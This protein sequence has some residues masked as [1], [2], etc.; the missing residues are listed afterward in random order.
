VSR[1]S[2]ERVDFL[3]VP[4]CRLS[5]EGVQLR[6]P[7]DHDLATLVELAATPEGVLSDAERHY[8]TWLDKPADSIAVDLAMEIRNARHL[9]QAGHWTLN[10]AVVVDE[11][12]I[13]LQRLSGFGRWPRRR[14]VGTSSWLTVAEQGAGH[15]TRARVCV[16][17]LAFNV[18][19][20]QAAMSWVLPDN[21]R[22][23]QVSERLG[24][25]LVQPAAS[26]TDESKYMLTATQWKQSRPASLAPTQLEGVGPLRAQLLPTLA[27]D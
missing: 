16:L 4:A 1:S 23:R 10:F 2:L 3:D 14:N 25:T 8:V 24:Y 26:P 11:R 9:P 19:A 20:A 21:R 17:D 27:Q 15:G 7:D 12:V 22:S 6:P 18:L 13:G 5:C